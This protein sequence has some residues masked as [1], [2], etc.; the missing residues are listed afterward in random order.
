MS[1][2]KLAAG[3]LIGAA[4]G[5][6][7]GI[8]TAPKAGKET[9]AD[10]KAKAVEVKGKAEKTVKDTKKTVEKQVNDYRDRVTRAADSAKQ[11]LKNDR[12]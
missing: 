5:F 1:K 7:T 12:K 11:E 8:L 3:A 9:R 2:S 10:L 6:V 4:A